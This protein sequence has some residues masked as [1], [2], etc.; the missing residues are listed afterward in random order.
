M[1]SI[2]IEQHIYRHGGYVKKVIMRHGFE[3]SFFNIGI[4]TFVGSVL[5]DPVQ[6]K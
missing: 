3:R 6:N 1:Y 5:D 4:R 2:Q